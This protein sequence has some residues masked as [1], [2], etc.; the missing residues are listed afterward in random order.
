MKNLNKN[1]F[2]NGRLAVTD[3]RS[4]KSAFDPIDM[5]SPSPG[6]GNISLNPNPFSCCYGTFI[7]L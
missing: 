4:P 5:S 7:L 3:I 1:I 6:G 2:H